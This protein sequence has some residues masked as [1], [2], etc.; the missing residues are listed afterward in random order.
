MGFSFAHFWFTWRQFSF[1]IVLVFVFRLLSFSGL[2]WH[3][4]FCFC[5]GVAAAWT[6]AGQFPFNANPSVLVAIPIV[7]FFAVAPLL[8]LLDHSPALLCLVG[9]SSLVLVDPIFNPLFIPTTPLVYF[10]RER[11]LVRAF[12]MPLRCACLCRRFI[13]TP[14][15]LWTPLHCSTYSTYTAFGV[16]HYAQRAALCVCALKAPQKRW[17][18]CFA[19]LPPYRRTPF[20]WRITPTV[21][22]PFVLRFKVYGI[23]RVY[24]ARRA[25]G[26]YRRCCYCV[27]VL[28]LS[29]SFC[30]SSHSITPSTPGRFYSPHFSSLFPQRLLRVS[31][32]SWWAHPRTVCWFTFLPP[33]ARIL[34]S[35]PSIFSVLGS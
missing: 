20:C 22:A 17:L 23:T 18:L 27:G 31:L 3:F 14:P 2:A 16:R 29:S 19:L 33:C 13:P 11:L 6:A 21:R 5:V 28:L 24:R 35:L 15:Y 32:L 10:A 34:I 9:Y 1:C 12:I 4:C 8:F 25:R 30:Y 26:A 7:S